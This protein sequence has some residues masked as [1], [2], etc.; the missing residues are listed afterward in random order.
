MEV[1]FNKV[2][3]SI[4]QGAAAKGR[5]SFAAGESCHFLNVFARKDGRLCEHMGAPY[6][7]E[8]LRPDQHAEA[9][10]LLKRSLYEWYESRLGQGARFAGDAD[11]F[12]I[13]PQVYEAL[14]PGEAI[15]AVDPSGR[16]LGV[17][18]VHP[19][20]THYSLGIVATDPSSSG[21]GVA[22][23]MVGSV[24]ARARLEHK[25][26]RL[27]S[28]LMN[29]DSYSLYTRLG[30]AP[31]VLYQ[32]LSFAV[33]PGGIASEPP[34][35]TQCV[36]LATA[37]EAS[38]IADLEQS[39]AGV[40]REKDYAFFLENREGHWR[41][42]VFEDPAGALKGVLVSSHHPHWKM[43][44][45]GCA[46]DERVAAALLWRALDQYRGDSTVVLV[47]GAASG[48][49]ATLYGWGGR[50][51]ELH[52]AQSTAGATPLKGV[53]FPTFLPESA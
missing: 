51:I 16:L 22:R 12:L 11:A 50:N 29:L 52:I 17:C 4:K 13:F 6:T 24:L 2:F 21:R 40:R 1:I 9:A 42:W 28:S 31:G 30:F 15:C 19:R 37:G 44:G 47:P 46:A 34:Q 10:L 27:V 33:P 8:T 20:E 18:F 39:I 43:T 53:F 26:V 5:K 48:L 32:D 38:K 23:A 35:E 41:T 14:D 7:L 3:G 36:R 25:P 45:P 49:V